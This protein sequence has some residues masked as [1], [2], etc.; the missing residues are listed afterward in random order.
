[1][2]KNLILI[3][4][5]SGSGKTTLADMV[6]T[7]EDSCISISVD[8]YFYD[9]EDKYEF[10][11]DQ[12][13]EAH[14]WCKQETETC[15]TQTFETIVIH[16]TFTRKW[17]IDPYLQLASS[18]GYEVMVVSLFDSGLNDHQLMARSPHKIPL[19]SIRTQRRRWEHDVFRNARKK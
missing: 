12:L 7:N 1:M 6:C 3:R 16:N 8:D 13:K 18:H 11:A 10:N 9:E 2:T 19:G 17:E 4:G 5:L 14:E 15:M